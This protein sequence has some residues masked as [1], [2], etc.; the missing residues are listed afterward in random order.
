LASYA[1]TGDLPRLN[2]VIDKI[3]LS[4]YKETTYTKGEENTVSIDTEKLKTLS[5]EVA[6]KELEKIVENLSSG[7]A[8]L[9]ELLQAYEEGI[10]YLNHCQ[11]RLGEAEAKIKVLSAQITSPKPVEDTNG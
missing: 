3:S 5:F 6:L 9:E 4:L 10:A 7:E 11:S 2:F 8:N 1:T